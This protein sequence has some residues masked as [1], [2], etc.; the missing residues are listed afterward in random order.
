MKSFF[1]PRTSDVKLEEVRGFFRDF[2]RAR[3]VEGWIP[4]VLDTLPAPAWAFV[5]LDL[6]LYEPTLAA[7]RYFYDR[8]SPGGVL[9]CDGSVF[10]PGAQK[11]VDEFS[12]ER[13]IACVTLGHRESVFIKR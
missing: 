7:L 9:I 10:C 8:L 6:T 4:E 11:A 2:P 5:H 1:P 13:D 3:I 12:A